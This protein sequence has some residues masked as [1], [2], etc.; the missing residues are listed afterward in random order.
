MR[1]VGGGAFSAMDPM[2]TLTQLKVD[3]EIDNFDEFKSDK[4]LLLIFN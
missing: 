1:S 2:R 4:I 3:L